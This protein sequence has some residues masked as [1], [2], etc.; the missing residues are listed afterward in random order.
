ML[1]YCSLVKFKQ[2]E[3]LAEAIRLVVN[4]LLNDRDLPVKVEAAIALQ[5]FLTSQPKSQKY[6][7]PEVSFSRPVSFTLF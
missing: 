5:V 4:A 6:I 7:E 2:E 1:H 3:V